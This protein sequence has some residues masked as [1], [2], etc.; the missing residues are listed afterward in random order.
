MHRCGFQLSSHSH[1]MLVQHT[2]RSAW[3]WAFLCAKWPK[4]NKPCVWNLTRGK[5]KLLVNITAAFIINY[6]IIPTAF[7]Q[8]S[9]Q[10]FVIKPLVSIVHIHAWT[11]KQTRQTACMQAYT[12][13]LSAF[14]FPR[15]YAHFPALSFE[16]TQ[17]CTFF[18]QIFIHSNI[19]SQS[20]TKQINMRSYIHTYV[21]PLRKHIWQD[22]RKKQNKT[23]NNKRYCST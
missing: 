14:S 13:N 7:Y 10:G 4:P 8:P 9:D 3:F 20:K 2:Q 6:I 19:T 22:T 12:H 1:S 11:L 23:D 18:S 5:V 21:S 15:A 17:F 16:H